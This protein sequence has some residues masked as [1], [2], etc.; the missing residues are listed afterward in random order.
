M[1]INNLVC[2]KLS[3]LK[4]CHKPRANK[5]TGSDVM[6]ISEIFAWL[7]AI[8][9]VLAAF[10]YIARIS[11]NK[12]LNKLS[13]KC[14]IPFGILL[15]VFGLIHGLLA[16]NFLGA[17]LSEISIAPV[18]FTFNWGTACFVAAVL[19]ALTYLF[20]K[21][22]KKLWMPLHRILTVIL[23]VL[24]AIHLIDMGITIF[25]DIGT[26]NTTSS[27]TDSLDSGTTVAADNETTESTTSQTSFQKSTTTSGSSSTTSGS[28]STTSAT[29]TTTK[30]ASSST[31]FSGAVLKDGTYQGSAS[32]YSGTTTVSV[33]VSGGAVTGITVVSESD[34]QN[35]F[36][37]AKTIISTIISKQSLDVDAVTG[38][39]FSSAG[40]LNATY[41]ALSN[42]VVS[43][44]L[45]VNQ[46]DLS[47]VQRGH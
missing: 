12:K 15:I 19:L 46:I 45:D 33:T 42:A 9:A 47:N 13:R 29:T 31:T 36:T 43:G 44:T 18:L 37:R 21:K 1:L 28:K 7:A 20:R 22:L 10:K 3:S 39:T 17:S 25:D 23:I 41:N 8:C 34:S 4:Y 2:F 27:Q 35:F 38:A 14:H 24:L 5:K 16:G 26:L 6:L 32:G 40:I 30:A 11:K